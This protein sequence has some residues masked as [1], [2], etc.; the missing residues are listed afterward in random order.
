VIKIAL[1]KLECY[2]VRYFVRQAKLAHSSG[3]NW[4]SQKNLEPG[5][6]LRNKDSG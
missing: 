1:M 4:D 6:I 5:E 3:K 2:G